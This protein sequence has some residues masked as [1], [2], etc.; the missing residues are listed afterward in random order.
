[1]SG[2]ESR[3]IKEIREWK[4]PHSSWFGKAMSAI[5]W[6][7]SKA[8]DLILGD[9]SAG[10]A[11]KNALQGVVSVCN[12]AA[13]WSVRP[14][15]VFE[16]FRKAGHSIEKSTDI[17]SLDLED[18]DKV[19]GFLA[20]K[21]KAAASVEGGATGAAGLP[22]IAIDIPALVTLNL[23]AIGEYA[24]Y[25]GFDVDSQRERLWVMNILG[26]ASSP[27]DSAK[28][29]AMA[30]LVRIA[31]DVAR[32]KPWKVLEKQA[33]VKIVKRIAEAVGI[34]ITKAKMAQMVP[35][36]GAAVGAGFNAYYTS[37]VCDAAYYLYRERFLAE[38]YGDSVV[39][40][41]VDPASDLVPEYEEFSEETPFS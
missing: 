18:I 25:Y 3:A 12:D 31:Q 38:K 32:R 10:Q 7:L 29:V 41:I 35:A 28:Q 9:H 15:A 11:I 33:F 19:I 30:Q 8:A 23:R 1:M 16:E 13:Q 6:P 22:G 40:A 2:Y 37:R 39:E 27:N 4:A 14:D 24:T 20:A 5:N 17:A 36:V 21:Y 34:R 26:Y